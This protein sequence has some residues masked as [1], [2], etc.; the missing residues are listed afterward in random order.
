MPLYE[1]KCE[2][3]N[4]VKEYLCRYED[5]PKEC[6]HCK[7]ELKPVVS[8]TSFELKGSGWYVT[9]YKGQK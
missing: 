9:D 8:K 7:S 3:C 1:L 5:K 6:E 2:Q 4:E